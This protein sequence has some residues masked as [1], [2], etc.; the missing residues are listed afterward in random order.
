MIQ[1]IGVMIALY[2]IARGVSFLSRTGDR[3]ESTVAG[4]FFV[5]AIIVSII[6]IIILL[7]SG[8]PM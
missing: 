3:Q 2:I 5:F 4:V 1:A 8:S 7:G 6:G